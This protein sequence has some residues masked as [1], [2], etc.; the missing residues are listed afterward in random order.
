MGTIKVEA[1]PIVGREIELHSTGYHDMQG[2]EVQYETTIEA[3]GDVENRNLPRVWRVW[4]RQLRDGRIFGRPNNPVHV[5]TIADARAMAKTLFHRH[6]RYVER[7]T[8][9]YHIRAAAAEEDL[10]RLSLRM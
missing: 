6:K 2:R 8:A 5:F 7:K 4:G 10:A 9:I 3:I 1:Y